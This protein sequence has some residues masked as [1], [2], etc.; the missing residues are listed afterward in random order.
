MR[1]LLGFYI[2]RRN[3]GGVP[4]RSIPGPTQLEY[5][6]TAWIELLES[7]VT[8]LTFAHVYCNLSFR[9]MCYITKKALERG[10]IK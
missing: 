3:N 7:I 2:V 8:I 1:D 10:E 6:L 5:W 4:G 9:Y